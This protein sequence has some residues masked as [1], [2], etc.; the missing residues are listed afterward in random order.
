MV[1]LFLE[2]VASWFNRIASLIIGDG[3]KVESTKFY[4]MLNYGVA[5]GGFM[6]YKTR[7]TVRTCLSI[8]TQVV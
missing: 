2:S 7:C 4:T 6:A 8:Q 1:Y 3:L 5:N